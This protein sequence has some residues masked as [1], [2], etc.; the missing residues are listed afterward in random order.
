MLRTI[1]ECA[2]LSDA[3][4]YV[5]M[6]RIPNLFSLDKC[7]GDDLDQRAVEIGAEIQTDLTRLP[8]NTSVASVIV[9]NGTFL[10]TTTIAVDVT[11]GSATFA[12][13]D[14]ST[15]P[16]AG[17]VTINAGAAN[18]EDLIYTRSG[19]TF[20]VVLSGTTSTTLQRSHAS[21]EPVVSVS[22]RSTLASGMIV[23]ATSSTLLAGTGAAWNA[24]GTVIFDRSKTTQ[25]KIAFTRI[26][27]VL[28]LGAGSSFAHASGSVVIQGTDGTD[29]AIPVGSQPNVPPALSTSQINFTVQQPGGTLFDGD[30]ISGLVPVRSVLAGAAT[31]VGANQITRWTTPPFAGATVTN[32]ISAT[33]GS[34]REEDDD[35]RQ[36]IKDTVQSFSG[37]GTPLSITTKVKGL[38][39]P[40]TGAA[41]AFVQMVEP[42]LPGQSLLY[43][44]DD[45]PGFSLRQQ[46]FLG[47]DVVISDASVGDARGKLGT[48]GPPYNYSTAVPVAPRLFSSAGTT[49]GTSTSVGVNFLEDTTQTMTVNA[50]AGMWVKTVDN[51]FRQVTSNT[52]V[53]FVFVT[54]DIP[55]SGSFSVYDLAG[56]PLTPGT[57]FDFNASTGDLELASGLAAHDGLVAASDGAS[58][59][60]GAYLYASGLAAHVQRSVNGDPADF[61]SFPGFRVGGTQVLV[62][63]PVTIS[64]PFVLSVVPAR[65]FTL[66]QLVVPIQVAVQTLVNAS[67]MGAKIEISDLIVTVKAVPGVDDVIPITPSANISVPSG[68]LMRIADTDVTPV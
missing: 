16:I 63:V 51:V 60:F 52:A 39:D 55:T 9:G 54:G 68:T 32:P 29:H 38:I 17:A 67:G 59:S 50:F 22:I 6:S 30:F 18:A 44:T 53:R 24:S 66:A 35:Y 33:R 65:G 62:A 48:Y 58:P 37:G 46:P 56:S 11:Y 15:F 4:Q 3:D 12:V 61:N 28:T 41:V 34:D 26:G 25:E 27:D 36:R 47:R 2:A 5:Q 10:K 21:S 13:V 20:T 8:A 40:E 31:R 42:V 23:G 7:R 57:D 19:N 1:L 45:T 43:I 14:G 49:R 64:Q